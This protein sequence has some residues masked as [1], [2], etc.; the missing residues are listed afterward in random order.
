M[1]PDRTDAGSRPEQF[2][3]PCAEAALRLPDAVP[4][5]GRAYLIKM[6]AAFAVVIAIQGWAL[7]GTEV[8]ISRVISGLPRIARFLGGLFPP[9]VEVVETVW[10]AALETL[11]IAI[12]GTTVAAIAALPLGFLSA[13]NIAPKSVYYGTRVVLSALRSVP[14]ILYA[15]V[16]VVAVGLGPLAG[17]L[18][19]SIYSTGMLGKFYAEAIETIDPRTVEGVH[20]TGAPTIVALRHGVIP[21]VLPHFVGYTLYRLEINFREATIVGLV[22]AGGI[23]FYITL[24]MRSFAYHRVATV[25]LIILIMVVSIDAISAYLRAKVV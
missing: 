10:G 23:G 4:K 5:R 11:Q 6:L 25:A 8:E 16:F 1:D 13:R 2:P 24:Y 22:G 19:V 18:A 3:T 7:G 14:L 9:N 17:T 12:I 21:Q 15:L 20:A